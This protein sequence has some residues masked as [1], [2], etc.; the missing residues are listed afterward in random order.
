VILLTFASSLFEGLPMAF[1]A[2]LSSFAES[3]SCA[4]LPKLRQELS[5]FGGAATPASIQVPAVVLIAEWSISARTTDPWPCP[6]FEQPQGH[7]G[8]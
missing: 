4:F 2:F 7:G 1:T 8:R 5:S 3:S 6:V